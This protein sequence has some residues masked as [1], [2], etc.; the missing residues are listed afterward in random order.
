MDV[1]RLPARVVTWNQLLKVVLPFVGDYPWAMD[2]LGDLWRMGAPS[3]DSIVGMTGERR[4]LLPVQF[5]QWWEDVQERRGLPLTAADIWG[6][7]P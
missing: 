4:V 1:R 6:R 5:A 3:P 7:L 2:V